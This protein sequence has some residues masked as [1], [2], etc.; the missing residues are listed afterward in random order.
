ML[1]SM[2]LQ[3]RFF[4][5]SI[6]ENFFFKKSLN[7]KIFFFLDFA[8]VAQTILHSDYRR[9]P[10]IDESG[11]V[12]FVLTF[13]QMVSRLFQGLSLFDKSLLQLKV[14]EMAHLKEWISPVYTG[15]SKM[16]LY[17][18]TGVLCVNQIAKTIEAFRLM[19]GTHVSAV[20]IVNHQQKLIGQIS[21]KD[22]RQIASNASEIQVL[23]SENCGDFCKKSAVPLKS[24]YTSPQDT[25]STCIL[26]LNENKIH[27]VWVLNNKEEVIGVVTLKHVLSELLKKV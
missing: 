10:V 24:L 13:S 1:K 8:I 15:D 7:T 18:I 19:M 20:P 14:S 23:Y 9:L 25:L 16:D 6:K 3:V 2:I 12:V 26:K 21:V 17:D 4:F 11:K 5:H 27:R 22:I